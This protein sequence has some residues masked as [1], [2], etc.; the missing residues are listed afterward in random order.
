MYLLLYTYSSATQDD[1]FKDLN[2]QRQHFEVRSF[3]DAANCVL[4]ISY[5][6]DFICLNFFVFFLNTLYSKRI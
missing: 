6:F 4:P 3:T 5:V 1:D 2:P